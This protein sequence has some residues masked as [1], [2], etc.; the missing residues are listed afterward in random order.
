MTDRKTGEQDFGA[1]LQKLRAKSGVSL[2]EASRKANLSASSLSAIEKGRSSP[3]LATM[4]RILQALGTNFADFFGT[5]AA[6]DLHPVFRSDAM[7][8]IRDPHRI[9]TLLF[10]RREDLRFEALHETLSPREAAPEW[11]THAFDVGGV[12][13][14]GGPVRLEIE[15]R[16]E[17]RIRRGD[18][19]YIK[20]GEKHR[21]C[22]EGTGNAVQVT[23]MCP[24]RY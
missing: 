19:F 15:G 22:N 9:Y 2:R 4:Q 14:K 21:A 18:A 3:T 8:T 12:L 23:I 11:E 13:L 7:A 17:W 6:P 1:R 20:A 10:P 24:L 5:P 16:G